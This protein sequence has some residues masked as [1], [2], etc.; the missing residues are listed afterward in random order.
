[1]PE[2]DVA[3]VF[4]S[5]RDVVLDTLL[6]DTALSD[7]V[8]PDFG[9]GID[10]EGS[11]ESEA[12]PGDVPDR[13]PGSAA[14]EQIH[15]L[16]HGRSTP[17]GAGVPDMSGI[18]TRHRSGAGQ[19]DGTSPAND[20]DD[21]AIPTL[22]PRRR[23]RMSRFTDRFGRAALLRPKVFAAAAAAF[24]ALLVIVLVSRGGSENDS[25]SSPLVVAPP[26]Q[27]PTTSTTA[28]TPASA[29]IE[30]RSAETRCPAGSTTGMDAVSGETGKAWSCVRAYRVDG[31][32]MVIDL[33]GT[34]QVD[35][36]GIVPGWDYVGPDG[37]DEWPKHRTVSRVSYE[38]DDANRTTYTQDTKNLRTLVVTEIDPP[39][40]TSRIVLT[41]LKS[42]G[43]RSVNDV[44]ISSIVV[45]GQ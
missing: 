30:I 43:D 29:P 42:S 8:P 31:Q 14:S 21:T 6:G 9:A 27:V 26:S 45:T 19:S 24:V 2:P 5:D 23:G 17:G 18:P 41:V 13:S 44:A 12:F 32:V 7:P 36:I 34:F 22:E 25:D 16:L 4:R 40:R 39:I 3:D 15:A 35:S 37:G 11:I 10:A 28:A 38:F 33:G 1:M 20:D